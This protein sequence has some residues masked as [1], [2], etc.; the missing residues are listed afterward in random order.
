MHCAKHIGVCLGATTAFAASDFKLRHYRRSGFFNKLNYFT[1]R[2]K[3]LSHVLNP[4]L[5][6]CRNLLL[7]FMSKTKNQQFG[8]RGKR[9]LLGRRVSRERF[10]A[11]PA[12]KDRYF[13]RAR[14][15]GR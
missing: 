11:L 2:S 15:E 4:G 6:A 9:S 14:D 10:G 5:R 13:G 3:R 7:K 1:F 12:C 8:Y